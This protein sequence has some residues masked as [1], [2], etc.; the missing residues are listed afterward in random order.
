MTSEQ[1][2]EVTLQEYNEYHKAPREQVPN[3]V[4]LPL[5]PENEWRQVGFTEHHRM[6]H[7]LDNPAPDQVPASLFPKNWRSFQIVNMCDGDPDH[8]AKNNS[9]LLAVTIQ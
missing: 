9:D 3:E 4:F 7:L 2:P 8:E 1:E 5:H 6:F